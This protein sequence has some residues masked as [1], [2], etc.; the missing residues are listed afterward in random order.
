VK[1]RSLLLICIGLVVAISATTV[2]LDSSED[3]SESICTSQSGL[4]QFTYTVEGDEATIT[5]ISMIGDQGGSLIIPSSISDAEKTYSV[6][7]VG[8]SAALNV[9]TIT[10][11]TIPSTVK[12]IGKEAFKPSN[13][14][15]NKAITINVSNNKGTLNISGTSNTLQSVTI[16]SDSLILGEGAFALNS[17]LTTFTSGKVKEIPKN[18]FIACG[19]QS[20]DLTGVTKIGDNAFLCCTSLSQITIP[21]TVTNIGTEAFACSEMSK[22]TTTKPNSSNFKFYSSTTKVYDSISPYG[23]LTDVTFES[24]EGEITIANN[25]QVFLGQDVKNVVLDRIKKVPKYFLVGFVDNLEIKAGVKQIDGN[26]IFNVKNPVPISKSTNLNMNTFYKGTNSDCLISSNSVKLLIDE[27]DDKYIKTKYNGATLLATRDLELYEFVKIQAGGKNSIQWVDGYDPDPQIITHIEQ[28]GKLHLTGLYK[29]TQFE[30]ELVI[31][32]EIQV[33][34]K[35][36]YKEKTGFTVLRFEEGSI[37]EEISE[38]A[39]QL[40]S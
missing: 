17:G 9:S 14:A 3:Y 8:P 29:I 31:P 11:I 4:W 23:S 18:C 22:N 2:I 33:I 6:V 40:T 12:E 36:V 20:Y 28:D 25:A 19:F 38:G 24:G 5:G 34:D 1:H 37:L 13:T 26:S 30:N 7:K 15:T 35:N 21:N 39:F 10:D 32:K 27:Y 16:Q